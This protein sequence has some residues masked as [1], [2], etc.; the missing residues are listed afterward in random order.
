MVLYPLKVKVYVEG[1][2]DKGSP[3]SKT[4]QWI[5]GE[6][7]SNFSFTLSS[8]TIDDQPSR[9]LRKSFMRAST[10]NNSR[11]KKVSKAQSKFRNAHYGRII[12]AVPVLDH[13]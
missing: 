13:L 9:I 1:W 5:G 12:F 7:F 2:F 10:F 3:K 6:R 8:S 4:H 11:L